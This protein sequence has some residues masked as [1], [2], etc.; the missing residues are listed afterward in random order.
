MTVLQ[1]HNV[2]PRM[3]TSLQSVS[4]RSFIGKSALAALSSLLTTTRVIGQSHKIAPTQPLTLVDHPRGQFSFVRG[5]AAYSAGVVA[6]DGYEIVHATFSRLPSLRDGFKTI[7]EHLTAMNVPK[8]ALCAAELRSPLTLS[9]EEFR[10][11]NSHYIEILRSWNILLE[12][13][14]NPIARTN[15]AP[16]LFPPPE[17]AI[18]GFSYLVR[19]SAARR[20]FIVAGGGE[21]PDGSTN[22]NDILRR[23]DT[24]S[25]ALLEKAQYVMTRMRARLRAMGVGWPDV[26]AINAYTSHELSERL[27]TEV[28]NET[29]HNAVT[30]NYARPPIKD[31]EFEMDLRGVRREIVL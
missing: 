23:G 22:A 13:D 3:V 10:T 7:D 4:R 31:L 6:R 25:A 14:V 11:F 18:Y 30:W 12:P 8:F 2:R 28:L 26:T 17:P 5:I 20:T 16:V 24:S 19:S 1:Q 21:L 29:G 15:V 9:S 27:V